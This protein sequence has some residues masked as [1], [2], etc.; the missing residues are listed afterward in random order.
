MQNTRKIKHFLK[1]VYKP[2][3]NFWSLDWLC[4]LSE[5]KTVNKD[6]EFWWL[7]H[8]QGEE[9]HVSSLGGVVND[10]KHIRFRTTDRSQGPMLSVL[11]QWTAWAVCSALRCVCRRLF[12]IIEVLLSEV[13]S[14][15]FSHVSCFPTLDLEK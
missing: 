2:W 5:F 12:E 8:I 14:L 6:F 10:R 4:M 7:V 11:N 9:K 1:R 3:L 13:C 15:V